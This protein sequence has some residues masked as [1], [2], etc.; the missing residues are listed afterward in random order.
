M[1]KLC[2][3]TFEGV[4]LG[5]HSTNTGFL[6]MKPAICFAFLASAS[7]LNAHP[8][9]FIDGG[10]DFHLDGNGM[11]HK[12]EVT[13]IY[14]K[15][16]TLYILS[17]QGISP[18][19]DGRLSS[20]DLSVLTSLYENWPPDFDGS[21]HLKYLEQNID[22]NWPQNASVTYSENR[23]KI[24]FERTLKTKLLLT[25]TP[26]DIGFYEHTYFFDFSITSPPEI[27]GN[28]ENCSATLI[29]FE[30][31]PQSTDILRELSY[32]SREET[33]KDTQIGAKLADRIHLICD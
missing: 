20:N 27:I 18:T 15:F 17:S 8:H 2:Y 5:S 25:N 4:Y 14:D 12:V 33:P 10:V 1:P 26:L 32:L 24:K 11:L 22:L 7:A 9:I 21:V 29:P 31:N 6:T 3:S 13:W 23:L 30:I 28:I 16:E 19:K